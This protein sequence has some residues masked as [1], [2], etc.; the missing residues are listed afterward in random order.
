MA[1]HKPATAVT[2]A[3][4]AEPSPLHVFVRRAWLPFLVVALAVAAWILY[5]NQSRVQAEVE[6]GQA[7]DQLLGLT[8]PGRWPAPSIPSGPPQQVRNAADAVRDTIAGPWARYAE[9]IA[10][11]EAREYAQAQEALGRLRSE[12][13]KHLLTSEVFDFGAAGASTIADHLERQ[14]KAAMEWERNSPGLFANPLPPAD[15]PKV[16]IKTSKGDIVVALYAKEAPKHV[17]NFL[18]LCREGTYVGLKFH[19]VVPSFMIQ[20]GD[21]N[22][23]E[24]A[25]ETW[26]QGG[27]D[28]QVPFETNE[29]YHFSDVLAMAKKPGDKD[30]SGSQF[31]LTVGK[32]HHLDGQHVVFGA[33]IEGQDVARA[34]SIGAIAPGTSDR[35]SAPE[36]ILATEV[37]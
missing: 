32:A 6:R 5:R 15:A 18:K 31:Y 16:R 26:G 2:I 37:P 29:L 8:T 30:S 17:E 3:P 25:P 28:Y 21:P 7:W 22:S 24:G 11:M 36:T 10:H 9:V 14:L 33:V 34:I 1:Q 19:R 13:G 23:K 4:L 27:P 12:Q 20:S 35:P